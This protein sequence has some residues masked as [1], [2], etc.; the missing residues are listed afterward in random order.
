MASTLTE[1]LQLEKPEKGD[2]NWDVPFNSNMDKIDAFYK[3]SLEFQ[4]TFQ[5]LNALPANPDANVTYF[6]Y[7]S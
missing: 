6:I 2:L 1:N 7:E 4:G 3:A 5:Y